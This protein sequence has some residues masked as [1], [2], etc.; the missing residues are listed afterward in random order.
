[1]SDIVKNSNE[2]TESSNA[3]VV[4]SSKGS[5]K[6][7]LIT[8]GVALLLIA[9]IWIWKSAQINNAEE[10]A[11]KRHQQVEQDAKDYVMQ[12]HKE[13]LELLAKPF[14]WA[15]RADMMAGN[16]NQINL[17][18]TDLVKENNFELV[19]IA[20]NEGTIVSST[21]KKDEGQS[22][23]TIGNENALNNNSTEVIR[24]NDNILQLTSPIMGFNSRLGTLFIRYKMD[25]PS[26]EKK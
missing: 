24:M 14:V 8:I 5:G 1:M 6:T 15:L 26:F 23:T 18:V 19:A 16:L 12:T 17:Y 7:L 3:S 13:H 11:Q 21:N 2:H 9:I 20:N 4:T 10:E 25:L 22:F